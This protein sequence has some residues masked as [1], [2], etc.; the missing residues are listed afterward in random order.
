MKKII[1]FLMIAFIAINVFASDAYLLNLTVGTFLKANN[2]YD[3][4]VKVKNANDSPITEF[5]LNWQIDSGTVYTKQVYVGGS[6]IV[7][8]NY[9]MITHTTQL[10][11]SASGSYKFKIW[12]SDVY[13]YD[14][15][16]ANDTITKNI[17]VL[18]NFV[19][20]KVLIEEVTAN[21]CQYC[22]PA[23][24]VINTI[25][26]NPNAVVAAFHL[27]DPYSFT[28][29]TSYIQSLGINATP[30]GL[31]N[32]GEMGAY[33]NNTQYDQWQAEVNDR[34][35]ISPVDVQFTP[36]YNATTR[37]LTI[38]SKVNFKFALAGD[39]YLN[40]YVLESGIS[41]TQSNASN[42]YTHNHVVRSMLNGISGVGGFIPALP[43][44]NT[45]YTH[46]DTLTIPASWNAAKLE[47]IAFVFDK[48]TS[49]QKNVLNAAKYYYYVGVDDV[50]SDATIAQVYP[51]PFTDKIEI[52]SDKSRD[53]IV[54]LYSID[55]KKLIEQ[56]FES[57]DNCSINTSELSKGIYILKVNDKE[58]I[59]TMK[60]IKQ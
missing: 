31:I 11:I 38:N 16:H 55:G 1:S 52:S 35:G 14:N 49:G 39:Y 29:G 19:D 34:M 45:D 7:T 28:N 4:K 56:K 44:V 13:S 57:T 54:S 60:I 47:V 20:K 42:P 24:T 32:L 53:L 23:N 30:K 26:N 3:V 25:A 37:L 17:Y 6:G 21:W 18:N 27:G 2:D 36:V 48:N 10:N 5:I 50:S 9:V 41:G 46:Q 12:V 15:N 22:P 43:V 40:V 51:N 8:G 59:Q 58:Q 33:T